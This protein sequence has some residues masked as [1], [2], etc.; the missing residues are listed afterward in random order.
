MREAFEPLLHLIK[1]YF[2]Q[3]RSVEDVLEVL[4]PV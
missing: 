3:G 2:D 4:M 1:D